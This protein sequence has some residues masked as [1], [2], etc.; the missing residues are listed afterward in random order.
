LGSIGD[1]GILITSTEDERLYRAK[2]KTD[3]QKKTCIKI[4]KVRDRL[5]IQKG[6]KLKEK[7]A[8]GLKYT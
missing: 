1:K 6:D 2:S 7:R 4:T 8:L 3:I 5:D